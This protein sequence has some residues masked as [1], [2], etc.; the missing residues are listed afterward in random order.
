MY[1]Q[2]CIICCERIYFYYC[3]LAARDPVISAARG[4][5]NARTA[6]AADATTSPR[7]R[8]NILRRGFASITLSP[9]VI[10]QSIFLYYNNTCITRAHDRRSIGWTVG[11]SVFGSRPPAASEDRAISE[12]QA[13]DRT[14]TSYARLCTHAQ[15]INKLCYTMLYLYIILWSVYTHIVVY[16][17]PRSW[18]NRPARVFVC[19]VL[20]GCC[21]PS[22]HTPP[23]RKL[24]IIIIIPRTYP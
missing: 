7:A 11:R 23:P 4:D 5:L 10:R 20:P 24:V 8:R 2:F 22:S 1:G 18:R 17:R 9:D 12:S 6:T 16:I 15:Y 14:F 21:R 3:R 13:R 19:V